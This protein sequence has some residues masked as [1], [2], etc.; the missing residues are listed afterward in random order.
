MTARFAATDLRLTTPL[1]VFTV[2]E[3]AQA[4][5]EF[6]VDELLPET[7]YQIAIYSGANG[8][9]LR[10]WENYVTIQSA[11]DLSD[12]N[13]IDLSNS[14]DPDAVIEAVANATDGQIIVL[15][16]GFLYNLPS[17]P[18]DKSITITA[19]YGLGG[20]KAPLFT[21]GSWNIANGATIGHIR[22]IDLE[23]RGE[24]IGGDYVFNPSNGGETHI[25]ELTFDNCVIN[26]FRG[27]IRIREKVF[28]HEFNITHSLV[29]N[30]GNYGIITTDTDGEG[31]AAFDHLNLVN[32]TFSKINTFLV[33][34]QNSQSITIDACTLSELAAPDGVVFRWRG[35]AGTR[36]NVVNGITIKNTI[37][38][39]AWDEGMTGNLAVRGIHTGLEATTFVILNTYATSDF[40]FTA[41]S[42]IPGFPS[43]NYSGTAANL[44]VSPYEGLD[45]RFKDGGFSGKNDAGDPRWRP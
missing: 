44:W 20:Q 27:I 36:S 23:L 37:W 24:D 19:A 29:H 38:G 14:E 41:G 16:K 42:E 22:F 8:E 32:S 35:T 7:A 34:R 12:P 31:N 11:I 2:D 3:T 15:K 26:H 9:I 43:L 17:V 45:F 28:L 40:A 30:I 39:H 21:T 5:G 1:A 13:V 4:S 33:S 10:G 18:L 25:N 6:I